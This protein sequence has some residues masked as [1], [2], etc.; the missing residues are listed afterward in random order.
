MMQ[1]RKGER[2]IETIETSPLY[3]RGRFFNKQPYFVI[4]FQKKIR[5]GPHFHCF[6]ESFISLH[7]N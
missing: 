7:E 5:K 2:Q 3:K 4:D 1:S 6:R